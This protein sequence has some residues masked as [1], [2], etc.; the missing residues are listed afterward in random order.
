MKHRA[1]RDYWVGYHQLPENSRAIADRCFALLKTNPAH[2]SLHFKKV[3]RFWSVRVGIH[4]RA[5]AVESGNDLVWFWIGHHDQ[6]ERLIGHR[7]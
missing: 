1:S 6:Y 4:Y 5:V 7:Q 3:G 2:P